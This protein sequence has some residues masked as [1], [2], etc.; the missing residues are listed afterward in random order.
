MKVAVPVIVAIHEVEEEEN[1][2]DEEREEEEEEEEEE[3]ADKVE[4]RRITKKRLKK[5][6]DGAGAIH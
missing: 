1:E 2:V 4:G 3:E 6:V 5:K